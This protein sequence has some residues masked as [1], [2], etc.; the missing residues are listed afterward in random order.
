MKS[1]YLFIGNTGDVVFDCPNCRNQYVITSSLAANDAV[2]RADERK[3]F[4]DA[5]Q[6]EDSDSNSVVRNALRMVEGYARQ[7][8]E[9]VRENRTLLAERSAVRA[10]AIEEVE[11]KILQKFQE[12][13]FAPPFVAFTFIPEI[14]DRLKEGK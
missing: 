5:L 8:D 2:V 14:A 1:D 3:K 10:A 12:L 7:N 4:I 9:L 13:D 6:I 11:E